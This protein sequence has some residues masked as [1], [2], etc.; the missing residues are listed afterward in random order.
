M[1]MRDRH[2]AA[3]CRCR[4]RQYE[5]ESLTQVL[6]FPML[7]RAGLYQSLSTFICQNQVSQWNNSE[8]LEHHPD[9]GTAALPDRFLQQ[10]RC[11]R[12]G[13]T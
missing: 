10:P 1:A 12:S 9:A 4:K 11:H 3:D 13:F 2:A 7:F 5:A 8:M 6:A